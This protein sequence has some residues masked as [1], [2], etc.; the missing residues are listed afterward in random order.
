MTDKPVPEH[1]DGIKLFFRFKGVPLDRAGG[2]WWDRTYY[3]TYYKSAEAQREEFLATLKPFL[4]AWAYTSTANEVL[5]DGEPPRAPEPVDETPCLQESSKCKRAY[6]DE[7]IA[8]EFPIGARVRV[9]DSD[10]RCYIGM[11]GV[12]AAYSPGTDGE[13]PGILVAFDADDVPNTRPYVGST[14]DIFWF[15][16]LE[17]LNEDPVSPIPAGY[18]QAT[19]NEI[20][21]LRDGAPDA[22]CDILSAV[23]GTSGSESSRKEP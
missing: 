7:V 17:R 2:A 13:W 15:E 19:A 12:V 3:S 6:I 8:P 20:Q 10:E 9:I 18:R 4:A 21:L 23:I 1:G 5:A 22:V 11:K 16:E 14:D